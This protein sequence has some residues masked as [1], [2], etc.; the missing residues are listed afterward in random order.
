M[1]L[2]KL[3]KRR[4]ININRHK[5]IRIPDRTFQKR[6]FVAVN[7]INACEIKF[8]DRIWLLFIGQPQP[9]FVV[10]DRKRGIK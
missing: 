10:F 9:Y 5:F 6:L 4:K 1:F 2:K 8:T 3:Q 7:F